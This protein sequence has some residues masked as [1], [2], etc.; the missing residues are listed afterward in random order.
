MPVNDKA[1]TNRRS[2]KRARAWSVAPTA[3]N[4][5]KVLLNK[6]FTQRAAFIHKPTDAQ[7]R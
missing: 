5:D 6:L 2:V 1:P 3:K 4:N 7:D